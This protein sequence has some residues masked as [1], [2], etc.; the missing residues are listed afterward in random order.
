MK[1]NGKI[2]YIL[3][4]FRSAS[5][6]SALL[7]AGKILLAVCP[8]LFTY[9][10]AGFVD[11]ILSLGKWKTILFWLLLLLGMIGFMKIGETAMA[12]LEKEIRIKNEAKL[13][14]LI[15]GKTERLAF[16]EV[17]KE[18]LLALRKRVVQDVENRITDG[19]V[20]QLLL[21]T[22]VVNILSV[23]FVI[24]VHVRWVGFV[25]LIIIGILFW[26]SK[27]LGE[28][29]YEA[30]EE[31][32]EYRRRADFLHG[33]LTH[34]EYVSEKTIFQYKEFVQNRWHQIFEKAR[35]TEYSAQVKTFLRAG[36]V[37]LITSLL[38]LC[39]CVILLFPLTGG[40]ISAGT[41]MALVSAAF[42]LTEGLAWG[43]SGAMQDYEEYRLY[44]ADLQKFLQWKEEHKEEEA[45]KQFVSEI[46]TIEFQNVSF[47]Y[48]QAEA[49]ILH[50]VSFR[51]ERGKSYVLLGTN[52]AGKSTIVKLLAGLYTDYEG[53]ILINGKEL[54][55][56]S[57]EELRGHMSFCFQ[58]FSHY[59]VS[60][61]EF[62]IFS[63]LTKELR[64]EEIDAILETV[65]LKGKK[66]SFSMKSDTPLGKIHQEGAELSGGEWQ[67]LL[68]ARNMLKRAEVF[69]LD[70]PTS[71]MDPIAEMNIYRDYTK[72]P[73]QQ[74]RISLMISHRL[75]CL[76]YADKIFVL[77][78]GE[79]KE[80]GT[81][82][83]LLQT[84]GIL[85]KMYAEQ[86]E[87]YCEKQ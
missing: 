65:G 3:F 69:V 5:Y 54:R 17:E 15:F 53:K 39:I 76:N 36:G 70:E 16:C 26:V 60:I 8:A 57:I 10:M 50:H 66:E 18:E 37:N 40:S 29:N 13:R 49:D 38:T 31:A 72:Y 75:G 48:P 82:E 34:R 80:E 1:G 43:L 52:G 30:F 7:M 19:F 42:S 56:Y 32:E 12:Y 63:G 51:M 22:Y 59:Q 14:N 20:N 64:E 84:Q 24:S 87:W 67:R 83:E 33:I 85:S 25:T 45:D 21:C 4:S 23:V 62:L 47:R 79:L 58:D 68:M 35:V 27:S 77:D 73:G 61:K 71:S 41:Y 44:G 78:E 81:K 55:N 28:E 46:N 2:S 74:N 6:Q 9:I 86:E 11:E